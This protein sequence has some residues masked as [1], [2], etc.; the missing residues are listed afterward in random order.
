MVSSV[1][2]ERRIAALEQGSRR[3][4]NISIPLISAKLGETSDAAVTRHV[5][6]HGEL[7]KVEGDR[8]NAI[9]LIPVAPMGCPKS[10]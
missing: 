2:L 4:E 6:E 3:E 8:V 5:A 10:T 9:V 7:P 1:N